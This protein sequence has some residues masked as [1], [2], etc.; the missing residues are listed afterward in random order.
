M[1]FSN[2][3]KDA[4]N[5]HSQLQATEEKLQTFFAALTGTW[6]GHVEC[7]EE[8]GSGRIAFPAIITLV[9]DSI[10]CGLS[11]KL[12]AGT[13][14]NNIQLTGHLST[15]MDG[16]ELKGYYSAKNDL[17]NDLFFAISDIKTKQKSRA[18]WSSLTLL[19]HGF[20][21]ARPCQ[22]EW[23]ILVKER[24]LEVRKS[25]D[26]VSSDRGSQPIMRAKFLRK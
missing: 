23:H 4:R 1:I 18:P 13:E 2:R 21:S 17:H 25:I 16:S 19:C 15:T 5:G 9:P 8:L 10:L 24:S 12:T 7:I 20:S 22:I 14:K 6:K 26:L 3:N 11:G